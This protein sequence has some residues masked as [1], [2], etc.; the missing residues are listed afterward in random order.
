MT[1]FFKKRRI[2]A[3]LNLCA[4]RQIDADE[5]LVDGA[6]LEIV[7]GHTERNERNAGTENTGVCV[8]ACECARMRVWIWNG[9]TE[10]SREIEPFNE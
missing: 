1:I 9:N 2:G 7:V 8:C 4:R 5:I 10:I 6:I 3:Y